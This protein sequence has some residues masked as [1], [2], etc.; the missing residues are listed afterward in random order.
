MYDNYIGIKLDKGENNITLTYV[1]K[2]LK[3]SLILSVMAVILT[4]LLLSTSLYELI[5]TNKII[6]NIAYFSYMFAYFN[7]VVLH[8]FLL[9]AFFASYFIK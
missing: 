4:I 8:L 7:L 6:N 2:G 9:G 1:P 5:I 3:L